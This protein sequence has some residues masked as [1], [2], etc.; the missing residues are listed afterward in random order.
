MYNQ[1]TEKIHSDLEFMT[2]HPSGILAPVVHSFKSFHQKIN[3]KK[4]KKVKKKKKI[5]K[6]KNTKKIN[7]MKNHKKI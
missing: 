5:N 4:S 2:F 1:T 6:M 7:K 3:L